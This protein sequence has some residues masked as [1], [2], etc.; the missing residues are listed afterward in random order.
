M[1]KIL[2]TLL[3][4]AATIPVAAQTDFN[5]LNEDGDFR[6]ASSRN[7]SPDS[8]GSN[9][10]IPKGIKV[11]TV[12]E[13]F[14]D[15]QEATVDTLQHMY[16]NTTFTEGIRGEYNTLGNMGS[17]RI[18]RIFIDRRNTQGNFI[19]SEP[20]SYV[21]T[22]VSDFH[23]TNTY[24]PFTNVTLNSC[25]DRTNGEDDFRAFFA[26]NANKRLGAGFKFDYKYGRG[27]YNAQS[28]SHFKYT[29]WAS[30]LGDRYQA[31]FLF[32]TLHQKVT[33]NGGISNDDYIKHP[34]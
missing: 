33:E 16:M 18:G 17:P 8:L 20:Y 19:F 11:W 10:K 2:A 26:V 5:S 7:L 9:Q 29:M 22:P 32:T 30:F 1:K 28:T 14:G 12:D 21:N 31:H 13:K 23:F 3:I 4:C 24:S 27:Y 25:G 6:P 34:E 15:R